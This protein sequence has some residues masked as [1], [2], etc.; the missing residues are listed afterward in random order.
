MELKT[1][2]EFVQDETASILEANELSQHTKLLSK[3]GMQKKT[4]VKSVSHHTASFSTKGDQTDKISGALE[5][6]GFKK[7]GGSGLSHDDGTKADVYHENGHT[8]V[9]LKKS[10]GK[11]RITQD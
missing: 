6:G 7:S 5:S 3:I 9:D 1:F 11:P 10:K 4:A 8:W 2:E